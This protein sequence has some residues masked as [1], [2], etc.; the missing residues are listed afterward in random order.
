MEGSIADLSGV[1]EDALDVA[2]P[3][4]LDADQM[5]EQMGMTFG[6]IG[7]VVV[8]KQ[9]DDALLHLVTSHFDAVVVGDL[10]APGD[11]VAQESEG[12]ALRLRRRAAAKDK[13]VLRAH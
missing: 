1:V 9:R 8:D 10:E 13:E 2:T 12:L 11:D 5:T 4:P 6:Q 3:A 7:T